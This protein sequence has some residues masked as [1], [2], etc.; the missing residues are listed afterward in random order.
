MKKTILLIIFISGIISFPAYTMTNEF[1]A[2]LGTAYGSNPEK[3]G[4][5]VSLNYTFLL[6]PYF[7]AGVEADMFWIKWE[8]KIG[9][10]IK[11]EVTGTKSDVTADTNAFTIP[12]LLNLQLRLP[13]L[14]D[15]IYIEPSITAGLGYAL[16]PMNFTQ[17]QFTDASGTEYSEDSKLDL[18]HGFV[19]QVFTSVSFVPS[20]SSVAFS[21]DL[22]YR[23]TAP[24]KDSRGFD[25]SGFITRLGVAFK[26]GE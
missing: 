3:F 10:E 8:Q 17:P 19:W 2:K 25:M 11:D 20:I 18:Y 23:S 5:D 1:T 21:L 13:N 15:K 22:G 9:D 4:L 24:E 16:M 7:T 26:I 6:D 14:V 12:I